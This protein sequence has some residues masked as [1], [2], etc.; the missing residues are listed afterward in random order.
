[1]IVAIPTI[2]LFLPLFLLL[3]LVLPLLL[4]LL[5]PLLLLLFSLMLSLVFILSL[6]WLPLLACM[7]AA[8]LTTEL[9]PVELLLFWDCASLD[10]VELLL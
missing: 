2:V 7:E 8:A 4:L 3:L 1:M 5:L 10:G 6:L 9:L